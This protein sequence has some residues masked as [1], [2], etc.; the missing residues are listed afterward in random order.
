[1]SEIPYYSALFIGKSEPGGFQNGAVYTI[2]IVNGIFYPYSVISKEFPDKEDEFIEKE[3][4]FENWHV[5][6]QIIEAE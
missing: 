2:A 5:F 1:M 4:F 6:N 3:T